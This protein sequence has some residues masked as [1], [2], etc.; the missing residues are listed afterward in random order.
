MRS[1]CAGRIGSR[2]LAAGFVF[3]TAL[4]GQVLA[5]PGFGPDPFWPYNQQYTPYTSPIGPAG[6]EGGQGGDARLPQAGF[7]GANQFEDYLGGMQGG[8]RNTSD[9]A[10]IG[11]PY[12]RSSVSPDYDTSG[13]GSTRQYRPNSSEANATFDNAQRLASEKYFAYFS[14]RDPVRRKEL[15]R[16]YRDARY[17]ASRALNSRVR[18]PSATAGTSSRTRTGTRGT[19]RTDAS[20]ARTGTAGRSGRV[21]PAP[22]VPSTGGSR[23][24]DPARRRTGGP[25]AVLERSQA[26]DRMLEGAGTGSDPRPSPTRSARPA[27]SPS[28]SSATP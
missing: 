16:E 9:R 21:G 15:L 18:T 28:A 10:T 26:M 3:L 19:A 14:E 12:Y 25:A 8:G 7:R 4:S 2:F 13:R 23:S 24:T 27:P 5:Q 11:Q 6:P 1:Q 17:Q 20:G 22:A